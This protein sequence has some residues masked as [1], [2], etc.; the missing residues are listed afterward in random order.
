MPAHVSTT[1]HHNIT[2]SL[3]SQVNFAR[4]VPAGL[5]V[6]FPSYGVMRSCVETWQ[7]VGAKGRSIWSR[8]SQFKVGAEWRPGMPNSSPHSLHAP[9]PHM[10][11]PLVEPQQKQEFN[12]AIQA[13]YD[14]IS[15]PQLR[16]AVFFAVC[17]GKVSE[18]LDFAN[19]NGR[20]VIITGLPYPPYKDP[21]VV[22][23]GGEG[24]S[25]QTSGA[26]TYPHPPPS[27][28]APLSSA[29]GAQARVFEQ[30]PRPGRQEPR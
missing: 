22:C 17:R 20:A 9:T 1:S 25:T 29:G 30:R 2:W 13:F 24:P 27:L 16:G 4:T 6:F 18:G 15:D 12:E 10:Q 7:A 11:S 19:N 5:L 21:K 14:K 26:H 3:L 28:L 23:R 8:I